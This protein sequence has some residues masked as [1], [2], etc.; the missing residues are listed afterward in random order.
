MN[1]EITY[2]CASA[3]CA[4]AGTSVPATAAAAM[5]YKCPVCGGPLEATGAAPEAAA[6][7]PEYPAD[8]SPE[9][10]PTYLAE[11]WS[12]LW[13]EPHPRLRLHWLVDTA[14]LAV[15]W[16]VA[17]ALAEVVNAAG[18][19]LPEPVA[20]RIR[21][22]IERPTLGRWLGILRELSAARPA[23]PVLAPG[24][25]DLHDAQ[26]EPRFQPEKEG[27]A[28]GGTL[29]S[30]FL[31]LRNHLAHGGGMS[32]A[33]SQEL[34]E[35]HLPGL[36]DL[37][38]AVVGATRGTEV[39][40]LRDGGACL[41]RGTRPTGCEAPASLAGRVDCPWL[42]G[43][44]GVLPLLPLARYGPVRLVD[45]SGELRST[46]GG[47]AAQV[48]A[49]GSRDRLSFT[50]LG[51]DEA[52]SEEI[53]VESFR[54]LLRLDAERPR[55]PGLAAAMA[56]SWDDFLREA[57]VVAEDLVGRTAELKQVKTWVKSRLPRE[58]GVARLGW[59]SGNPGVGKSML[60]ARL[61]SDLANT[62]ARQRGIFYH[63]FRGGDA[64][65]SRRS[66]LQLL[67]AALWAWEPLTAVTGAPK[68]EA[69]DG[70]ELEE[71]VKAR[72]GAIAAL[73]PPRPNSP[74]P[75][76]CVLVDGLDE[77]VGTDSALPGLLRQLAVPGTTWLLA[78]R[79][80][81]GLDEA[82]RVDR[83][84]AVF[85]AGLP[86]MHDEDIRAMLL[87]G[88]GQ[89]RYSLL[90]Q[91]EER[92][93][94]VHNA[95]VD[96]V[97]EAAKGLPLYVHLLLEDLRAGQL[98]VRDE[99]KLPDGL[100]AYYD[101]LMNR[102]GVSDA[103]AHLTQIVCLLARAAEPLDEVGL[104][105]LL[106]RDPR[107]VNRYLP[108]VQAA[109]RAGQA[110]VRR[111][112]SPDTDA[113]W[114][115]YHQSFREY[116]GGRAATKDLEAVA[117]AAALQA[118]VRLA[119]DELAD[120][121]GSWEQLSDPPFHALRN[122]LFR[123]GTEYALWWQGDEGVAAARERLTNFAYLQTRTASL[124]AWEMTDLAQEYGAVLGRLPD[125]EPRT[126]FRIWGAF[127]RERAH[128]LRR[129][130]EYWPANRILLQ[131]AAEHADD[132]PV[133]KAAEAWL[134]AGHCD[135]LWL[136][137]LHRPNE[138]RINP[139]V[140]VLEGHADE[141]Q[142]AFEMRNGHILS[143]SADGAMFLWDSS[144][145]ARIGLQEAPAS[146]IVAAGES[147]DDRLVTLS[148][149]GT[150][151]VWALDGRQFEVDILQKGSDREKVLSLL[152]DGRLL[153][154]ERGGELY[155]RLPEPSI[156][157]I[158]L[159][160][161]SGHKPSLF[162]LVSEQYLVAA[163]QHDVRLWDLRDPQE[164]RLVVRT[165]EQVKKVR[166]LDA[167]VL[168][169]LT[170][171]EVLVYSVTAGRLAGS[172]KA[173]C[174]FVNAEL[175]PGDQLVTCGD[176]DGFFV[177]WDL[178]SGK[179]YAR[180]DGGRG[181]ARGAACLK[182]GRLLTWNAEFAL[183]VWETPSVPLSVS[184]S[185]SL[186]D[187]HRQQPILELQGHSADLFD[188]RILRDGRILTTA[189]D[190]TLRL[191]N[192]EDVQAIPPSHKHVESVT[193]VLPLPDG[194]LASWS[195]ED[196][197]VR[198]W[199]GYDG[200][201]VLELEGGECGVTDVRLRSDGRLISFPSANWPEVWDLAL[202]VR[203]GT[204][205][206]PKPL[207]QLDGDRALTLPTNG[208]EVELYDLCRDEVLARY[209]TTNINPEVCYGDDWVVASDR[210][211]IRVW[212]MATGELIA[213]IATDAGAYVRSIQLVP[214]NRLVSLH[215][216]HKQDRIRFWS[217]GT[218]GLVG[219]QEADIDAWSSLHAL[220]NGSVVSWGGTKV[221]LWDAT[222]GERKASCEPGWEANSMWG[223]RKAIRSRDGL[224]LFLSLRRFSTRREFGHW[225][226]WNPASGECSPWPEPDT[227]W[228]MTPD[229]LAAY[230]SVVAGS[231]TIGGP[232]ML[233]YLCA[234]GVGRCAALYDMQDAGARL[235]LWH[236]DHPVEVC[237]VNPS[238]S[239]FV[240]LQNGE[241][242]ALGL[243]RGHSRL[244]TEPEN[245][246]DV[247]GKGESHLE[248]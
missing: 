98:T 86:G 73:E 198:V 31:V 47:P 121:A 131:L 215:A 242:G 85:E 232:H 5:S 126:T 233:G 149:D 217:V 58:E 52:Q 218:E 4:F 219:L 32:A 100:T 179:P 225:R 56:F 230:I 119:E 110:L 206:C 72:L 89:A 212:N 128:I 140:S 81:Q 220:E 158:A 185:W 159:A 161:F 182:D 204:L 16:S 200:R 151:R 177:L 244:S 211:T 184:Q 43:E 155:V 10:M 75:T 172:V 18:G 208:R 117:P 6:L 19:A 139:C 236:C 157:R 248:R 24:V 167:G 210:S 196:K 135:W 171:D 181:Q 13:L 57:R 189:R 150:V 82:F 3:I 192:L 39:L 193:G 132:S 41:L 203:T 99:G 235:S 9:A 97:V 201:C 122:H 12:A 84:E 246:T 8:L 213:H 209:V 180:L 137:R 247:H 93:D 67:Q 202:G 26:F 168:L 115:L 108:L 163:A 142:G 123:W 138:S 23:T 102:L 40:A 188:A 78:G 27:G 112:P 46:P 70:R 88:L 245:A 62:P 55:S 166:P 90:E 30:S 183:R 207:L 20:D 66:F 199:D 25:F 80:E 174:D 65:N 190:A 147:S 48:Y 38:R 178:K 107:R 216:G 11:P 79:P 64:R 125:G 229:T 29:E 169:I 53:D 134:E 106:A 34:L 59:V 223:D 109:L 197:V 164:C 129:G 50:P 87:E 214:G 226:I 61:A 141:I 191:W 42:V 44:R 238:G 114:T 101:A 69:A 74:A 105:T 162:T 37:L 133:T 35:L 7:S 237:H 148:A 146:P 22:H 241:V 173:G 120:L 83:C 14:E 231:G 103:K 77:V 187:L 95:F 228:P 143:W 240:C 1:P 17:V 195:V 127:F 156:E 144:G 96:R 243:F 45:A 33:R 60:V 165:K 36:E 21:D 71:D 63:R 136:R 224:V 227:R 94:A 54:A 15:R 239:I 68:A 118:S 113:A 153:C 28:G 76:F 154:R 49:R 91:D 175:L 111:A 221:D 160:P 2:R 170:N 205:R 186:E 116:V 152:A 51:R 145:G 130:H 234:L 176:D 92:D 104:A 222:T 194:G 124:P